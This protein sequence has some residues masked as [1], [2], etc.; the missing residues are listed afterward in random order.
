MIKVFNPSSFFFSH[1]KRFFVIFKQKTE[2]FFFSEKSFSASKGINGCD[3]WLRFHAQKKLIPKKIHLPHSRTVW[4][5]KTLIFCS[6]PSIHHLWINLDKNSQNS[7]FL[8]I[9]SKFN[10]RMIL[11]FLG[12]FLTC[13]FTIGKERKPAFFRCIMVDLWVS[14]VTIGFGSFKKMSAS[15]F[16]F[17][18]MQKAKKTFYDT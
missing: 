4:L 15:S 10:F 2:R 14:Y 12:Y 8:D 11:E 1:G 17:F 6:T 3:K 5:E 18:V 7:Q 13:Y 9:F 16:A